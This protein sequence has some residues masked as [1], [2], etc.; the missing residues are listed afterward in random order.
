MLNMRLRGYVTP[1][2]F[3]GTDTQRIQ[4]AL[5][6]SAKYDIGRVVLKGA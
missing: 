2:D 3:V 6:T 1:E 5:D 4:Q